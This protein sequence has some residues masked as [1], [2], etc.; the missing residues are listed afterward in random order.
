[1][2]RVNPRYTRRERHGPLM[3]IGLE[4]VDDLKGFSIIQSV[5]VIAESGI[6][7]QKKQVVMRG[8]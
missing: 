3:L 1:M 4:G 7:L 6:V 5:T 2:P 8:R